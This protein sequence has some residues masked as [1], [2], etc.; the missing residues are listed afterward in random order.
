MEP[1]RGHSSAWF[2]RRGAFMMEAGGKSAARAVEQ[3]VIERLK[4]AGAP[5]LSDADAKNASFGSASE[6]L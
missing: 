2:L 1:D 5:L 3:R 6:R 4:H